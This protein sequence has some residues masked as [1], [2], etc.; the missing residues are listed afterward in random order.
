MKVGDELA[1]TGENRGL[2]VTRTKGDHRYWYRFAD[3]ATGRQKALHVGYGSR[4]SLAEARVAF[5]GLKA[6]RRAGHVPELP[7]H[8][9]KPVYLPPPDAPAAEAYTVATLVKDYLAIV[10]KRRSPKA[11]AEAT[12]VLSRCVVDHVGATPASELTVDQCLD[13]AHRELD[14][15]HEAQCG[16]MLRE[17]SAAIE[18]A[19]VRRRVPLDHADP[20]AMA[21]RLLIRGGARLTAKRRSRFLTDPE[22]ELLLQWLPQSGFSQNQ[23]VAL[24]LTLETGCRTG[25]AIAAQWSHFDLERGIWS[26]PRTKTDAPRVI[27]LSKQTQRWASALFEIAPGKWLCPSPKTGGHIE[28][29]TLTE[30]MWRMRRDG[31]LPAMDPWTPHDLRRTVRTALARLGCPRP[32]A[33]AILGHSADGIVGVYDQHSYEA[34]AGEWLQRWNDHLDTLRPRPSLKAVG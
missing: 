10:E 11:A 34:E 28:Q 3:P 20:A 16:V 6:Q 12:R 33:E 13:L 9:R 23:R 24:R 30:T 29:K 25:E 15:G 8:L 4:M 21:R 32:I 14:A 7:E 2:R 18:S 27:R 26:L 17:L 31:E 1:D 19:M 5:A 22:L